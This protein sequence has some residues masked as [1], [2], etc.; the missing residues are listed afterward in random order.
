MQSFAV[1]T[2]LKLQHVA[3]HMYVYISKISPV[4]FFE[5]RRLYN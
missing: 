2:R 3:T 1:W 5:L 4:Y